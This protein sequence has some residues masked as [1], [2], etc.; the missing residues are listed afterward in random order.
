[1]EVQFLLTGFCLGLAAALSG[2]VI[3]FKRKVD[4]P[5]GRS[6]KFLALLGG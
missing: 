3:A 1:V 6:A 4:K 5:K 2:F